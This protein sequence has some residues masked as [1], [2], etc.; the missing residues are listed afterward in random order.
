[1][2][3]KGIKRHLFLYINTLHSGGNTCKDFVGDGT[4]GIG[5]DS[6]RKVV[7]EDD[8]MVTWLA[9]NIR[10]VDHADIHADVT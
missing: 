4:D 5:E 7:A 10:H 2:A 9:V 1:M 8:S 6:D 3:K